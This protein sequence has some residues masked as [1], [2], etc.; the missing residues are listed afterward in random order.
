MAVS[1][2]PLYFILYFFGQCWSSDGYHLWM[3]PMPSREKVG[4]VSLSVGSEHGGGGG[5]G[6]SKHVL[7]MEFM[8]NSIVSNPIVVS[9]WALIRF[10]HVFMI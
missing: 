8:R 5:G 3:L 10:K 7:V 2:N 4:H 1:L 9:G 6:G